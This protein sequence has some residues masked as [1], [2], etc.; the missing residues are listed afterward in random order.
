LAGWNENKNCPKTSERQ[1]PCKRD[2][3]RT[4]IIPVNKKKRL[5]KTI[6]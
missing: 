3:S 1:I 5:E 6:S 4:Y 2:P